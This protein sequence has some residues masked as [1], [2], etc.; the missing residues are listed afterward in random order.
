[1][2]KKTGDRTRVHLRHTDEG[3]EREEVMGTRVEADEMPAVTYKI[4]GVKGVVKRARI[5]PKIT[6]W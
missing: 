4:M 5:N 6:R 2:S 3:R 1:M